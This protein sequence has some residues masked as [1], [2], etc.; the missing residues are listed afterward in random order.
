MTTVDTKPLPCQCLRTMNPYGST[1]TDAESW[2]PGVHGLWKLVLFGWMPKIF[3][4]SITS[5]LKCAPRS[6]IK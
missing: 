5:S 6:K 3:T 4:A 2:L 1:P